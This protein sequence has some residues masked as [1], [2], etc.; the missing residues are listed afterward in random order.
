[1][2]GSELPNVASYGGKRIVKGFMIFDQDGT[3]VFRWN[4]SGEV[5]RNS[6]AISWSPDSAHVLVADDGGKATRLFCAELRDNEWVNVTLPRPYKSAEG[7]AISD[8]QRPPKAH[9]ELPDNQALS[10]SFHHCLGDLLQ[11]ADFEGFVPPG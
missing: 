11:G 4:N 9:M 2:E 5:A 6:L 1:V 10:P 7:V 8:P 3:P